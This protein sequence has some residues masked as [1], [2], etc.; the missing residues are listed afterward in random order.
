MAEVDAFGGCCVKDGK[1]CDGETGEWQKTSQQN[2]ARTAL[3][4]A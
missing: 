4:P 3:L 1:G 2:G